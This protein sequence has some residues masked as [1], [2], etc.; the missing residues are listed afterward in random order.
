MLSRLKAV[1]LENPFSEADGEEDMEEDDDDGVD[2][3][4]M[5][6]AEEAPEQL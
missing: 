2:E 6:V 1:G 4:G 5:E 3:D